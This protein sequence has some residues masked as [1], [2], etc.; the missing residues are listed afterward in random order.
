MDEIHQNFISELKCQICKNYLNNPISLPCYKHFVCKDPCL[1]K[2]FVK[3]EQILLCKICVTENVV[4]VSHPALQKMEANHELSQVIEDYT[5]TLITKQ[6]PQ[7]PLCPHCEEKKSEFFCVQCGSYLCSDCEKKAHFSAIQ[8]KHT[9]LEAAIFCN[10]HKK[11]TDAYCKT[12]KTLVCGDCLLSDGPCH[13]QDHLHL[14]LKNGASTCTNSIKDLENQV[15]EIREEEKNELGKMVT[16]YKKT[17]QSKNELLDEIELKINDMILL[18]N[19]KKEELKNKVLMEEGQKECN[20]NVKILKQQGI[21]HYLWFKLESIEQVLKITEERKLI[22]EIL[23]LSNELEGIKVSEKEKDFEK[24]DNDK[25]LPDL[26]KINKSI[27]E[28]SFD[29]LEKKPESVGEE[30]EKAAWKR[31]VMKEEEKEELNQE[32]DIETNETCHSSSDSPKRVGLHIR[33]QSRGTILHQNQDTSQITHI[34]GVDQ[35]QGCFIF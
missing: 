11:V 25:A 2:L 20:L 34:S 33:K 21:L 30:E 17:S 5:H 35:S 23:E 22:V 24:Y 1:N 4:G 12:N 9:N 6:E 29:F 28:L 32:D 19:R 31:K 16:Q 15:H 8:K 7:I 26:S 27:E 3:D 13:Q 10:I 14:N 18:L